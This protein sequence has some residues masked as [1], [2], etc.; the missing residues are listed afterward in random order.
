MLYIISPHHNYL[1]LLVLLSVLIFII[2]LLFVFIFFL[3]LSLFF[4]ICCFFLLLIFFFTGKTKYDTYLVCS[5]FLCIYVC[6]CCS[7]SLTSFH[8]L[9]IFTF[10][11]PSLLLGMWLFYFRISS[12]GCFC[13]LLLFWFV[14]LLCFFFLLLFSSSS[15]SSSYYSSYSFSF[16]LLVPECWKIA[17]NRV[18]GAFARIKKTT[19]E[20]GPRN[21]FIFVFFFLRFLLFIAFCLLLVSFLFSFPSFC[22]LGSGLHLLLCFSSL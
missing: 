21:F 19:K 10:F 8:I 1:T 16:L 20:E 11:F 6:F 18:L 9:H 22:P 12:S 4:F 14:F 5:L 7:G 17:G 13:S 3:L 15:S 2:C